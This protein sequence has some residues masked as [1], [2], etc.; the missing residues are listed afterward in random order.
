[1]AAE[2][3]ENLE[4][5]ED[6]AEFAGKLAEAVYDLVDEPNDKFLSDYVDSYVGK[7]KFVKSH[8]RLAQSVVDYVMHSLYLHLKRDKHQVWQEVDG[9]M[10]WHLKDNY[11]GVLGDPKAEEE[12]LR[13]ALKKLHDALNL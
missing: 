12:E 8:K 5:A 1:M 4:Q 9:E 10:E 3:I 7:T 6:Y 13:E 11:G 2:R